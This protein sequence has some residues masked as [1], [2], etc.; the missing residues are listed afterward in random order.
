M[1]LT[2]QGHSTISSRGPLL[3]ARDLHKTY[4]MGGRD[5]T[6]LRGVDI[7]VQPGQWVSILGASGSGKST[8]LHLLGALDRPDQ[9]TVQFDGQDVFSLRGGRLDHYRNTHV[10]FV[11][12]FYH[13]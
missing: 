1:T 5:L 9:G 11:F 8:L 13:L 4:R 10:G 2:T 3:I 12:Q 7:Q 6:V